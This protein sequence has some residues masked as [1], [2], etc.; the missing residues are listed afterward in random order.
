MIIDVVNSEKGKKL[1]YVSIIAREYYDT[2]R[3][4]VNIIPRTHLFRMLQLFPLVWSWTSPL[5][6]V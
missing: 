4:Q 6:V 2:C 3:Y 1:G 5:T